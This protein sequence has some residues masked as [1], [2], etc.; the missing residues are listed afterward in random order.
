MKTVYKKILFLFVLICGLATISV[1][2]Q[3]T[4]TLDKVRLAIKNGNKSALTSYL[5]PT[6]DLKIAKEEGIYSDKQAIVVLEKFFTQSPATDFQYNH[7]GST[8]SNSKYYS[9][10]TYATATNSY[11]VLIS[12]KLVSGNY[13]IDKIHFDLE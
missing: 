12:Y 5:S 10:G 4:P 3:P 7:V 9:I 8:Q 13:L 2:Q 6:I 1:A 11:R